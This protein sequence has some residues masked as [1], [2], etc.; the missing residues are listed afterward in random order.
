[1]MRGTILQSVLSRYSFAQARE[2]AANDFL[3]G[4]FSDILYLRSF[5]FLIKTDNEKSTMVT[6]A[7]V[8]TSATIRYVLII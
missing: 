3:S 6:L 8:M 5:L 2:L 1:M 4:N 7:T